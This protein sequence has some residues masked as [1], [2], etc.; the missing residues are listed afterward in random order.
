MNANWLKNRR[1]L[2]GITQEELVTKL[3]IAG[4]DFSP[5][6]V[7]HWETGRYNPPFEDAIFR[8]ALAKILKISVNEMLAEAGYEIYEKD[9][10]YSREALRAADI[11]DQLP[12]EQKQLALGILEQFLARAT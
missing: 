5:S 7:S 4:L 1:K 10:K 9:E 2:L 3:Q 12:T 6:A 11:V 8:Q